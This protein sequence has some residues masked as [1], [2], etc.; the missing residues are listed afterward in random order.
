MGYAIGVDPDTVDSSKA[1][2][3]GTQIETQNAT[4]GPR[5]FIYMKG[6]ASTVAGSW[7]S[8][9]ELFA[10]ALLVDGATG[11][12][13]VA[14]A[15]VVAS[16]YGWYQVAGYGIASLAASCADNAALFTTATG[17]VADDATAGQK[18]IHGAYSREAVTSAANG[19]VSLAW[20]H[21][22]SADADG[23]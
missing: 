20:P 10:T 22:G 6:V 1:F 12:V 23:A 18:L 7:V 13:A 3:L 5:T 17:G 4:Y 9:D 8:Y 19:K 16:K 14:M 11:G 15:A 2:A 21:V